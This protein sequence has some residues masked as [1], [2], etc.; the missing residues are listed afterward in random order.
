MPI[1]TYAG[2]SAMFSDQSRSIWDRLSYVK[3]SYKSRGALGPVRFGE[4]TITDLI[5]MDLYVNGSTLAH[6]TQTTKP[7]EAV[8]GKDFEIW[9]GSYHLGWFRF[10]IQAK[11]I[12]LTNDRYS[13]LTQGN[14]NGLQI[15]LLKQDAQLK[16][17]APLYCLYNFTEKAE[18][19]RHYH[20]LDGQ[21]ELKE[22]GCTVTPL[23]NI[24]TAINQHGGKNFNR[25]HSEKS[26]LPWR[27]LVSCPMVQYSLE[28]M[29][30]GMDPAQVSNVSPLFDPT[31]CY[32]PALPM[33]L[34]RDGGATIRENDDGS[35][36]ISIPLNA[37]GEI[38]DPLGRVQPQARVEFRERY[39]R[40]ARLP[41][42]VAVME[43]QTLT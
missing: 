3:D 19:G 27:C 14:P 33:L 32:H 22:L 11:K 29:A 37:D 6:F 18:T 28:A 1:R 41:N 31:S 35:A 39:H 9:L 36:M 10:A 4:E 43:V 26:T 40:E 21:S 24:Q 16:Q 17:A 5:M 12:D 7:D 38:E 8:S 23:S 34:R 25:I 20:C 13:G 15:D 2:L 30:K 42:A